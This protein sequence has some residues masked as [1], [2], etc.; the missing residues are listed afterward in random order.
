MG[1]TCCLTTAAIDGLVHHSTILEVRGASIREEQARSPLPLEEA[2]P[3]AVQVRTE[4]RPPTTRPSHGDQARRRSHR[5]YGRGSPGDAGAAGGSLSA[6]A[7]PA[8][9]PG[10]ALQSFPNRDTPAWARSRRLAQPHVRRRPIGSKL[11]VPSHE[12][13]AGWLGYKASSCRSSRPQLDSG[14]AASRQE[15][16]PGAEPH[17]FGSERRRTSRGECCSSCG[18]GIRHGGS[19][20]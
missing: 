3:G 4:L 1:G 15:W 14:D 18:D 5:R 19:K 8:L 16:A 7:L 6:L 20:G 13:H 2:G 9:P 12:F 10:S 17:P 11:F